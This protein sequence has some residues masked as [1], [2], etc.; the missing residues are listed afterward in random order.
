MLYYVLH[1]VCGKFIVFNVSHLVFYY[2]SY[3]KHYSYTRVDVSLG[4]CVVLPAS[5]F[6]AVRG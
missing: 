6:R 2:V 1:C 4:Y 3:F 5:L